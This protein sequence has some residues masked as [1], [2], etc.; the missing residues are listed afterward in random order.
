MN[1]FSAETPKAQ[2]P[3]A[4]QERKEHK[5]RGRHEWKDRGHA[6]LRRPGRQAHLR[7][8]WIVCFNFFSLYYY[9]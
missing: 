1:G 3:L 4:A 9:P 5:K 8:E 2:Q 6:C 7:G